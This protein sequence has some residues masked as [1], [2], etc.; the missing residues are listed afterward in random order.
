MHTVRCTYSPPR[1]L[2][3]NDDHYIAIDIDLLAT[4]SSLLCALAHGQNQ[5]HYDG[6]ITQPWLLLHT[7]V[8]TYICFVLRDVQRRV[9]NNRRSTLSVRAHTRHLCTSRTGPAHR[10]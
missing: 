9:A 4:S 1:M 8:I 6:A 7:R 10:L 2:H 3:R 5:R